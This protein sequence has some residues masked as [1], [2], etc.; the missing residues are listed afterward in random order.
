MAAGVWLSALAF[1]SFQ[2]ERCK[3][4]RR[5]FKRGQ[6]GLFAI[7]PSPGWHHFSYTVLSPT[8]DSERVNAQEKD[9]TVVV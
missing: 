7:P 5:K 8:T 2:L 3:A 4:T 1:P 6:S 9:Y